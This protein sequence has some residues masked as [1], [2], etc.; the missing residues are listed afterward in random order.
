[1]VSA[2]IPGQMC[3]LQLLLNPFHYHLDG[4]VYHCA[5]PYTPRRGSMKQCA[6][7]HAVH[8]NSVLWNWTFESLEVYVLITY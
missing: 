1:M 3:V 7:N 6:G 8:S 5:R 2:E 4:G